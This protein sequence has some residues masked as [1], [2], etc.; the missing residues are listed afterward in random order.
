MPGILAVSF[1]KGQFQQW[2]EE[3][4]EPHFQSCDKEWEEWLEVGEDLKAGN[5]E[6]TQVVLSM[7]H[8]ARDEPL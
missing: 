3:T 1:L 8:R 2:K 7:H 6:Q 5:I 4:T